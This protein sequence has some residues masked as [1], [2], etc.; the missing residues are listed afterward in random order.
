MRI[1]RKLY[2][3]INSKSKAYCLRYQYYN[4]YYPYL[5]GQSQ[6][7]FTKNNDN[8]QKTSNYHSTIPIQ[9]KKKTLNMLLY[10][11]LAEIIV[12]TKNIRLPFP[13]TH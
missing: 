1:G 9:K 4:K 3:Q 13:N 8:L 7:Y 12:Y 5:P 10:L 11:N 2:G 6:N